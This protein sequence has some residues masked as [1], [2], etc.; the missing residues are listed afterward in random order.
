MDRTAIH[1]PKIGLVM[2]NVRVVRWLKAIGESVAVGDP[3]LELETEKST[4]EVESPAAGYLVEVARAA[5][6]SA[7]VGDLLGWLSSDA[8]ATVSPAVPGPTP[9]RMAAP[10]AAPPPVA[11]AAPVATSVPASAPTPSPTAPTADVVGGRVRSSPAARRLATESTLDLRSLSARV[12]GKPLRL[13]DVRRELAARQS[14]TGLSP[15]RRA[16]ARAM[17]RS[18]ATIPQFAVERAANLAAVLRHRAA[19]VAQGG[20]APRPTVTDY[21]VQA[22]AKSLMAHPALNATFV[23]DPETPGAR[24]DTTVGV[25]VGLVVAVEDG[26]RLPVLQQVQGLGLR[27][28]A[29]KRVAAVERARAGRLLQD[30]F[31]GATFGLSNLGPRGPDRF[32][33]MLNAPQSAILAV[34]REHEGIEVVNGTIRVRRVMNLTLTVDHRI[35][36]GRLAAEFLATLVESLEADDWHVD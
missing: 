9:E 11:A 25:N 34:G 30:D 3:L 20:T 4:V 1:L 18:A 31:P 28:I 16:L 19:L 13:A 12:A 17:T 23:G 7:A 36:D 32:N 10:M 14:G 8:T 21:L 24:I 27:A 26:L 33:A 2:E 22:I 5:G 15:M 6:A 29:A 35:I